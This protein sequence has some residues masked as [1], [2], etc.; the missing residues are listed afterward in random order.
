MNDWMDT[1]TRIGAAITVL[2]GVGL[3]LGIE[4]LE[5]PDATPWELFLELLEVTPMVV[6]VVGV[7]LLFR[8][9]RRQ[10]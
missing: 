1:R 10:R 2:A 9:V 3:F 5:E 4:I 7:V 8:I 6:A